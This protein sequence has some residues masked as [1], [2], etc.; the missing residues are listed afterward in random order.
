VS[1]GGE[2]AQGLVRTS[3]G[4]IAS[5]YGGRGGSGDEPAASEF[6]PPRGVF[7]V[8]YEDGRAIAFGGLARYDETT[9]EIRRMYVS[10]DARGRGLSRRILEALEDEASA[11]GYTAVRLE[12]GNRQSEA[13]GLYRSAGYES[14]AK[15]G[16]YMNDERSVCLEKSL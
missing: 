6:E 14:I 11:L 4:E 7:L 5:R 12:T 9:G 2:V 1:Y 13:L 16:P 10:P 3:L 8:G 15:Y